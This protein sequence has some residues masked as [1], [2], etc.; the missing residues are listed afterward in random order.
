MNEFVG[1]GITGYKRSSEYLWIRD[2]VIKAAYVTF[3]VDVDKNSDANTALDYKDKWVSHL[4]SWNYDASEYATGA[5]QTSQ[6]WV[7]AEA[8]D[9]LISSTILTLV[10]I[11][12]L[13]FLVMLLFTQN[14]ALS[15][16]S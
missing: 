14:V 15:L 2:D 11:V 13:A 8:Q 9:A 6:L 16:S 12:V 3:T 1:T 5:F 7:Q 4:N 10:I